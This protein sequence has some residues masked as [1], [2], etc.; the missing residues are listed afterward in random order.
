M[1]DRYSVLITLAN[2]LSAD[3]FYCHF[4]GK[5]YRPSEAEICHLYFIQSAQC[6]DYAEEANA[7][8]SG[9]IELPTCPV[10]LERLDYDTSGIKTTLCDHSFQCPCVQKWTYLSCQVCRLCQQQDEK[11]RCVT[12]GTYKNLWAC[13]ICGFVGCGRYEG[14][15]AVRHSKETHH[16]YSLELE[17]QQVWDYIGDRYVHRLNQSKVDG[18]SVME[19]SSCKSQ[20]GECGTCEFSE[21]SSFGGALLDSKIEA[22]MDEYNH[23]L[24]TQMETQRRHYESLLIEAKSRKESVVSEQMEEALAL[25]ME[26]LQSKLEKYGNEKTD[27]SNKNKELMQKQ[28]NLRKK[29][30]EIEEREVA[31]VKLMDA[32]ILDLEEQIRDMT[33]YIEA[34]KKVAAM[35]DLDGIKDG[36]ILPVQYNS[37]PSANSKRRTKSSR[38]RN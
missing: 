15:H 19:K 11:P 3:G 8:P 12:C 32:A 33:V 24:A 7:A 29:A 23:L 26:D 37:S 21:D 13:V 31:S 10:C 6:F 16:G 36:T 20:E 14:E 17:K 4:N 38:K 18:K 28:E 27:V 34:Q 35:S 9:Y 1:E 30:K 25:K 5:R 2:Q 22:I